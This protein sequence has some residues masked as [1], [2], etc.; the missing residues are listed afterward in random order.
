ME[1]RKE[2]RTGKQMSENSRTEELRIGQYTEKS[3]VQ[4]NTGRGKGS[5]GQDI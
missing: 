2:E 5:R 1:G 3:T 4:G